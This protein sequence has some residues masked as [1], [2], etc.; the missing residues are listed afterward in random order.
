MSK[1]IGCFQL[2]SIRPFVFRYEFGGT[3]KSLIY[4]TSARHAQP[5]N[6]LAALLCK[7]AVNHVAREG[8]IISKT[9]R[10]LHGR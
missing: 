7:N 5:M 4:L 10:F 8:N 1:A 3:D 6:E 9:L 2:T